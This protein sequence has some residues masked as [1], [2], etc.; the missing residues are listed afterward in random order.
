[1]AEAVPFG[2]YVKKT[3]STISSTSQKFVNRPIVS[4]ANLI[5]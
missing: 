2:D 5:S 1:M 4:V 3:Y